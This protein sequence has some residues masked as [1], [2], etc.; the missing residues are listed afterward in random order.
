MR[1]VGDGRLGY[2][3]EAPYNAIHVGAAAD[4]LPQEVSTTT[5]ACTLLLKRD[6]IT[7][8][9]AKYHA[10]SFKHQP[11][12]LLISHRN[13]VAFVYDAKR[14]NRSVQVTFCRE[15]F[16]LFQ[17]LCVK[18]A[19]FCSGRFETH[20]SCGEKSGALKQVSFRSF[21]LKM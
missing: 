16:D 18:G 21:D 1:L 6:Y 9:H 15:R 14:A 11:T 7:R 12:R 4:T 3:D 5:H 17:P 10:F 20:C 2:A 13:C 8:I 19:T